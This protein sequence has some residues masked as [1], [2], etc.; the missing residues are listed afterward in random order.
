MRGRHGERSHLEKA[1]GCGPCLGEFDPRRSPLAPVRL[2]RGGSAVYRVRR[3]RF[4]PGALT[5]AWCWPEPSHQEGHRGLTKL[6]MSARSPQHPRRV[7]CLSSR[8]GLGAALKTRRIRF[9]SEG[10]HPRS[11]K[12]QSAWRNPGD[13]GVASWRGIKGS[14][15]RGRT[16]VRHTRNGSSTLPGSTARAGRSVVDRLRDMEEIEGSIPSQRT[17]QSHNGRAFDL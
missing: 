6:D 17:G 1:Q 5:V 14:S 16:L 11:S 3:V 7:T 8:S 9:D 15:S 4:P 12:S 2:W 13:P 10:R